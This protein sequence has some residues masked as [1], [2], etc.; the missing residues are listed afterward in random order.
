MVMGHIGLM[1][2][3][4]RKRQ[5]SKYQN[6]NLPID[7]SDVLAIGSTIPRY[8]YQVMRRDVSNKVVTDEEAIG[9]GGFSIRFETKDDF[10]KTPVQCAISTTMSYLDWR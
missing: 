5:L 9:M 7:E 3:L 8:A 6:K 4:L 10:K 2:S 1:L